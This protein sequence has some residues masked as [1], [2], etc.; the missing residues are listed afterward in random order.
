MPYA[1]SVPLSECKGCGNLVDLITRLRAGQVGGPCRGALSPP[2]QM[3]HDRVLAP[4]DAERRQALSRRAT[5]DQL[6]RSRSRSAGPTCTLQSQVRSLPDLS[7]LPTVIR[8]V[9]SSRAAAS[10]SLTPRSPRLHSSPSQWLQGLARLLQ[11]VPAQVCYVTIDAQSRAGQS[12]TTCCLP[13]VQGV[14]GSCH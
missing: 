5:V 11:G 13:S 14:T 7:K 12:N 2:V 9:A 4:I 8:C 6:E 3:V 1:R 10:R